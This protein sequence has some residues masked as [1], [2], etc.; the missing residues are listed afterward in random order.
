VQRVLLATSSRRCVALP[1]L[2]EGPDM[3]APAALEVLFLEDADLLGLAALPFSRE[4]GLASGIARDVARHD[5]ENA[6]A[7]AAR[8]ID[9]DA[10]ALAQ[11][12]R[13]RY[14]F[15]VF[16]GRREEEILRRAAAADLAL[17]E[18]RRERTGGATGR[19]LV[20]L[21]TDL[22]LTARALRA[23][24]LLS[25]RHWERV[26][27]FLPAGAGAAM[28]DA[29]IRLTSSP[30]PTAETPR[31]R[32]GV[33]TTWEESLAELAAIRPDAMV[34]PLALGRSDPERWACWIATRDCLLALLR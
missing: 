33:A 20:S 28:R 2:L 24:Y 6:L 17:V 5:I 34:L 10:R 16:R 30:G 27:V 22:T 25:G 18:P 21:E 11:R 15:E 26:T 4:V 31:L 23:A 13:S 29:V 19:V 14:R 1:A 12:L 32:Q 7:R 9:A 3:T 8:Q